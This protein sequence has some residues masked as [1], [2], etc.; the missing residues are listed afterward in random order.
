MLDQFESIVEKITADPVKSLSPYTP[1][2][3]EKELKREMGI[4]TVY[5]L[6]SNE[7]PVGP[8][9]LAIDA[10][11]RALT[12]LHRYPDGNAYELREAIASHYFVNHKRDQTS[13]C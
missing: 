13:G 9:P 12:Q 3:P 6:A 1:G 4:D 7:N 11:Q 2:K 5:K 8:S 10:I